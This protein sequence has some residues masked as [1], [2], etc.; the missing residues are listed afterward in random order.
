MVESVKSERVSLG[1]TS[2]YRKVHGRGA[3]RKNR[4]GDPRKVLSRGWKGQA[5]VGEASE[6]E[7]LR[8]SS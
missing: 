3:P 6:E 1:V 7:G 5:A 4:A 2:N 8:K